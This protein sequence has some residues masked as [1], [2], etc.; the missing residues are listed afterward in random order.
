MKYY[1]NS[2]FVFTACCICLFLVFPT[3][4][5]SQQ[6]FTTVK[7]GKF[8]LTSNLSGSAN[9]SYFIDKSK[10]IYQGP[11][12]FNSSKTDSSE[13]NLV[14]GIE[15]SGFYKDGLKNDNW[16]F[17]QM[18]LQNDGVGIA[19]REPKYAIVNASS[20]VDFHIQAKFDKGQ[21]KGKW[22]AGKFK[23][24]KGVVIDTLFFAEANFA[25][26]QFVGALISKRKKDEIKGLFDDNGFFNGV[27]VFTH[28]NG[29][30]HEE[31]VYSEGVLVDHIIRK[32]GIEYHLEHV[33]LDYTVP[34]D[35]VDLSIVEMNKD[36]FDILVQTNMKD[37]S[38][39]GSVLSVKESN[40]IIRSSNE[41][42]KKSIISFSKAEGIDFWGETSGSSKLFLPKLKVKK[43][44]LSTEEKEI[45]T[46]ALLKLDESEKIIKDYM[47]DPQVEI[48]RNA[49]Q[50]VALFYEVFK[51]SEVELNKLKNIFK[52]LN[53]PAYEFINRE[54][55]FKSLL[56]NINYPKVVRYLYAGNKVED[57]VAFPLNRSTNSL[58]IES[59]YEHALQLNSFIGQKQQKIQ[60]IVERNR[61]QAQIADK[62][63]L[64][65]AYKD[66]IS[67]MYTNQNTLEDFNYYHQLFGD[68][69]IKVTERRF[70]KYGSKP[71]NERIEKV[72]EVIACFDYLKS[73]MFDE[74]IALNKKIARLEEVY[75]RTVWN[76]FT[77]TDMD[78]IVKERVYDAYKDVLLP[79]LI[80]D[81]E[82]S[83]ACENVEQKM[84][85]F[86]LLYIKMRE[87]REQDTKDL[88]RSLRRVS[89]PQSILVLFELNLNLN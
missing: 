60:P 82:N 11:F 17:S 36:Y 15:L 27:W 68:D 9:Y 45:I 86:D 76:P 44:P 57:S 3:S 55:V 78:E 65:V 56:I 14:N 19:V 37:A 84:K 6:N 30:I 80:T 66:S 53:T 51:I 79:F 35:T 69:I 1:A 10:R 39:K 71:V 38:S 12:Y 83:L 5:F 50:D 67:V 31:R 34:S 75:T 85:N 61:Q 88:E 43:F 29:L 2:F 48:S 40:D 4:T 54:D 18:Q 21:A 58:S 87:L 70:A 8:Q 81:F 32:N 47:S 74:L 28:Q 77:F 33:G 13:S 42:L 62:E 24:D 25:K 52:S 64:L 72:D 26:N 73:D 22:S 20:G 49:Y 89:N 7:E 16:T 59:L 41:F 23:I 63:A 46:N